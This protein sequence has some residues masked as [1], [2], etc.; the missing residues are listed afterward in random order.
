MTAAAGFV[1]RRSDSKMNKR[2]LLI[3][4]DK[5]I[6]RLLR[7]N[8]AFEG[9]EV[10]W[11]EM[12]DDAVRVANQF[13]PDLVLLD[14][15]L[16]NGLDGFE[17]CRQFAA[18]PRRVSVII[19]SARAQKEDRVRG[20]TL[21]ADDYVIKPFALDEL[22]AR[23]NAVLR[24][25]TKR[26]DEVKLGNTTIDFVR[27]RAFNGK[28]EVVLTQREFELLRYLAERAG[29]IVSRDEL[30]RVVWGYSDAPLT[31]TVDSFIFR[32]RHKIEPDPRHPK[33]ILKAYGD[34]YQLMLD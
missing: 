26:I 12:G 14:L 32:L 17:L 30:L 9:F 34:G 16:P 27:L 10:A 8:L 24:R 29:A 23:I 18:S 21:G 31:R 28:H 13:A 2:I 25:T 7:D 19:L 33:Y 5:A 15:M 11:S 22:L 20:L 6:A 3:E 4:D 1:G